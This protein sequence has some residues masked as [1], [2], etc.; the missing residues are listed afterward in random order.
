MTQPISPRDVL[1]PPPQ[2]N[3]FALLVCPQSHQPLDLA[4]AEIVAMLNAE[5]VRRALRDCSG[6]LVLEL[7]DNALIRQDRMLLYPVRRGVAILLPGSGIVT[8]P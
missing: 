7:L 5:I 6:S 2:P 3:R 4:P 8:P 1:D